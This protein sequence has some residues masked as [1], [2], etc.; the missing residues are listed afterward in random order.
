M[1]HRPTPDHR[2]KPEVHQYPHLA[3][4]AWKQLAIQR[5]VLAHPKMVHRAVIVVG[6]QLRGHKV[7]ALQPQNR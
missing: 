7:L 1:I 6:G 4:L 2:I 5:L 3:A